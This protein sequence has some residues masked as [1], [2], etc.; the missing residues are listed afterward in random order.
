MSAKTARY[1]EIEQWL[2]ERCLNEAP[3]TALPAET[4]LA[5]R[6]SVSRMTAR[7]AFEGLAREGLIERHRGVGS[8]V[9]VAPL[10]RAE[11]VLYSFTDDMI[12]RGVYPSSR[13]LSAEVGSA[14]RSASALGLEPEAWLVTIDRVRLADGIPVARERVSL[15]HEFVG[16]LDYDLE[17]GSLHAALAEM[18]R[19]LGKATG[20]VMGRLA[21]AEEGN[22]LNL[23]P[24]AALLV[25]TRTVT[26]LSGARVEHTETSY[27]GS[28][29]VIDTGPYVH[30]ATRPPANAAPTA[31]ARAP[32]AADTT[33]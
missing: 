33:R 5:V 23:Y 15:P 21:S 26:D 14:P 30:P 7:H 24:P 6:F 1:R 10:H 25:E 31:P 17:S 18:G 8:F 3:G 20:H 9:A 29:W 22:L 4:E 13:L 11:S 32:K 2:R 16:V 12:R 19:I 28:R 27:V